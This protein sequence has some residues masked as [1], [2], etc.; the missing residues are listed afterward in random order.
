M[1]ALDHESAAFKHLEVVFPKLLEAKIKAGVFIRLQIK[2]LMQE[3]EFS[4]KLLS[5]EKHA[6]RSFVAVVR[7]FL[8]NNK[9]ENYRE[10]VDNLLKS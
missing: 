1:K 10:L 4:G 2:K 5:S 7:G 8:C 3:P 9:E 6:W